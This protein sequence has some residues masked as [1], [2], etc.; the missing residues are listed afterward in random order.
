[1]AGKLYLSERWLRRQHYE[2][3]RSVDDIARACGVS[4]M[5]IRRQM[6]KFGMR[7]QK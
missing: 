6:Q 3:K 2:L 5:T 1:M 4:H 7:I